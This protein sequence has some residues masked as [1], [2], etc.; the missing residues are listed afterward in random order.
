MN[1]NNF[2]AD[3]AKKY[4]LSQRVGGLGKAGSTEVRNVI[5]LPIAPNLPVG[6]V[7]FKVAS[8]ISRDRSTKPIWDQFDVVFMM[9]KLEERDSLVSVSIERYKDAPRAGRKTPPSSDYFEEPEGE[10]SWDDDLV[11]SSSVA[12]Y[13]SK[14]FQGKCVVDSEGFGEGDDE[15][16][17]DC[18]RDFSK[19]SCQ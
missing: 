6:R 14:I 17:F 19:T 16:P 3:A 8:E 18:S 4:A 1:L 2:I 5:A 13:F 15:A 12:D 11:I 10:E 7:R 9:W